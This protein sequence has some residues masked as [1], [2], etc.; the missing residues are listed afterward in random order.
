MARAWTWTIYEYSFTN[1]ARKL[2]PSNAKII[3]QVDANAIGLKSF[4]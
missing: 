4:I 3:R 1:M 2:K